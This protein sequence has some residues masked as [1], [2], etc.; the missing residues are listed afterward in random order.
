MENHTQD[1]SLSSRL[2]SSQSLS[3]T[4]DAF[5][6]PLTPLQ[7]LR[8]RATTLLKREPEVTRLQNGSYVAVH[9]DWN[10]TKPLMGAT[11]EEALEALCKHLE[12]GDVVKPAAT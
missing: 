3:Q 4:L 11:E 7:Q 10:N 5:T 6:E 12:R 1:E 2:S 9:F 8:Q